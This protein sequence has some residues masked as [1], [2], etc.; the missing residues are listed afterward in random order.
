MAETARLREFTQYQKKLGSAAAQALAL[1]ICEELL[2]WQDKKGLWIAG[3]TPEQKKA[4]KVTPKTN[5]KVADDKTAQQLLDNVAGHFASDMLK[6]AGREKYIGELFARAGSGK[7]KKELAKNVEPEARYYKAAGTVPADLNTAKAKAWL[8]NGVQ[9]STAA[10]DQVVDTTVEGDGR[11]PFGADDKV[12]QGIYKKLV[13][14]APDYR[15]ATLLPVPYPSSIGG[16]YLMKKVLGEFAKVKHPDAGD[17]D[18]E[19]WALYL[20]GALM[21]A[22][23]FPDGNKRTCRAVYVIAILNA[24][25]PFR[26]PTDAFGGQLAAMR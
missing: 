25:L 24:Q 12:V 17:A 21:T 9:G 6:I 20:F 26:A 15:A 7:L 11:N 14:D 8:K 19:D 18:W 10:F 3:A 16:T 5:F 1:T 22:Q 13:T 4:A 2:R 23:P